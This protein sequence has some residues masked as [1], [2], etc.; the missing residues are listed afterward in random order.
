[1]LLDPPQKADAPPLTNV[2]ALLKEWSVEAGNDAVL[3]PLSRLR[4][5]E[6]DVPVAAPPVS[7]SRD[8]A[9]FRML[10]AYPFARS[11]KPAENM[12]RRPDR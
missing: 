1:M 12:A 6:A 10:T 7:V 4:G 8:H 11:V 3:D 2:L 5:A 9:H